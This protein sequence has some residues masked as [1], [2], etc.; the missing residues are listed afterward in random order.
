MQAEYL[1]CP[2]CQG[3]LAEQGK[4]LVCERN[5]SFDV[6]RQGYVN[7]LPPQMKHSKN[8]GDTRDMVAA[9]RAFLKLGH[10][11]PIGEKVAELTAPL[12]GERPNVLDAGC[13]E[14]YYL[15][16]LR[17]HIPRGDFIG[18]DISKDAVRYGA[19]QDKATRWI[20][21]SAAHLPIADET[22]DL[23]TSMFALTVPEEFCRV[24]KPGGYFLEVTAGRGHLLGLKRLIYPVLTEKAEKPPRDYPGFRLETAETLEFDFALHSSE[25]IGWLLT[26]TPHYWRISKEGAERAAAARELSDR[27]QIEYRLYQKD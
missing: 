2:I 22:M 12:V 7:L 21:A 16:I 24:L 6:A 14:G 3:S 26:M 25:E 5:H 9:R 8:P 20:T 13:G 1:R 10:Y 27:A 19:G 4:S 17:Q 18:V 23:V 15:G 11:E